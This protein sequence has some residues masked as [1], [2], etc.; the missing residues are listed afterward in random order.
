MAPLR[1]PRWS[2]RESACQCSRCKRYGFDPWDR[3]I[4]WTRKKAERWRYFLI[5]LLEKTWGPL[6]SKEIKPVN[7]KENQHWIFIGRT[8][9][10][11]PILWLPDVKSQPTGKDPDAGKDWR[12]E[13]KR[14]TE[15]E[16]VEWHHQLNGHE[17]EKTPGY[18][19][20]QG[21]L[22]CCSPW[23][24]RVDHDWV[25]ENTHKYVP[26][27]DFKTPKDITGLSWAETLTVGPARCSG[28]LS[29][30]G[31]GLSVGRS[32]HKGTYAFPEAAWGSCQMDTDGLLSHLQVTS[33]TQCPSPRPPSDI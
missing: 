20:G 4:S 27:A 32:S 7:P 28:L 26:L 29:L 8:E 19:E 18:S 9:A 13:E 12:Q 3:K 5:V 11:T 21:S 14:L 24:C 17:F 22:A 16:M 30:W 2:S 33:L 25:T 10:E 15:D 31:A 6:D 23:G 1:L